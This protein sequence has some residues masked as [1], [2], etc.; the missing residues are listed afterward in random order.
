[1]SNPSERISRHISEAAFADMSIFPRQCGKSAY[2]G[3]LMDMAYLVR[4][5]E[6]LMQLVDPY[7]SR[8]VDQEGALMTEINDHL[9]ACFARSV[10]RSST[11]RRHSVRR[12]R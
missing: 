10:V 3:L 7:A 4:S 2:L 12:K 1:M 5:H 8:T 6:L 9:M 11:V